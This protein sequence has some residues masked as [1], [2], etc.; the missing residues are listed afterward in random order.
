MSKHD[1][2]VE[3]RYRCKCGGT[4]IVQKH[5]DGLTTFDHTLPV[6]FK[7]EKFFEDKRLEDE[8]KRLN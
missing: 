2:K 7:V 3:R 4:L 8:R 6:C 5:A 1:K